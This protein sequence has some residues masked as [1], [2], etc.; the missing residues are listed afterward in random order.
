MSTVICESILDK[1]EVMKT[2]NEYITSKKISLKNTVE[3][4]DKLNLQ[5][6]KTLEGVNFM[7]FISSKNLK[8]LS[9]SKI[10]LQI[11]NQTEPPKSTTN[12]NVNSTVTKKENSTEK[13]RFLLKPQIV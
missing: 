7:K 3:S 11:T 5:F 2:I 6:M 4:Q 8:S 13:K 1:K 12:Q 9:K 10:Y